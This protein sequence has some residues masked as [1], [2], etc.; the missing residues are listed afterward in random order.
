[1]L[2]IETTIINLIHDFLEKL[3]FMGVF[4][5]MILEPTALPI[6]GEILLP[7]AGWMIID[8]WIGIIYLSLLATFG[9]TLGCIIEY[10]IA[11]NL[12][13]K[14]VLKYGRYL[15][16]TEKDL[17]KQE[18]LFNKYETIFVILSRFIPLIPKSLTSIIAGLYKMNIYKYSFY[19]FIAT[20]PTLFTYIYIGNK[21]GENYY[22]IRKYVSGFG[23]PILIFVMLI[24]LFYFLFKLYK[25]KQS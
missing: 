3:D 15:F 2:N 23:L 18:K 13:R 21:L 19:T 24:I 12:G 8:N 17:E 11:K 1:M 7:L 14:F 16:I 20:L 4:I 22:E 5:I 9:S 6:P 10:Y 25:M